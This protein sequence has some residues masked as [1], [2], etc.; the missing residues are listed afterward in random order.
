ML[1]FSDWCRV[2]VVVAAV[3]ALAGS[4]TSYGR[5]TSVQTL[6][7][8]AFLI[9]AD[10]NGFT[11][12]STI[13]HY[14]YQRAAELCPGGFDVL[15]ASS[16]VQ[17]NLTTFDG[18]KT[19]NTVNKP[20]GSLAIRCRAMRPAP[21]QTPRPAP[22]PEGFMCTT[23]D[24]N[25]GACFRTVNECE[26]FRLEFAKGCSEGTTCETTSCAPRSTAFCA[27]SGCTVTPT[28][29]VAIEKHMARDGSACVVTE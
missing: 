26:R 9:T 16:A 24:K 2:G 22:K 5:A 10:G 11:G 13:E 18:G 19:Y 21:V 12:S 17:T 1:R 27:P 7:D 20:S 3:V 14:K 28:G 4:A 6:G 8:G 25:I 23:D 15:D 29:C